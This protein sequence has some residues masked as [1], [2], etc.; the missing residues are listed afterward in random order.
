[1]DDHHPFALAVM[2]HIALAYLKKGDKN[3]AIATYSKILTAQIM[4]NEGGDNV[5][6]SQTLIKLNMLQAKKKDR[7]TIR[8]CLK[9]V[10]EFIHENNDPCQ[11]QRLEKLLK[12]SGVVF[13]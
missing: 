2:D 7:K 5:H 10:K 4:E 9:K 1:M 6:C 3:H 8:A 13:I 12:V 11:H